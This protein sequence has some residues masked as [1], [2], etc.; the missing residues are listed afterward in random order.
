MFAVTIGTY[1]AFDDVVTEIF[2]GGDEDL[3]GLQR[4]VRE[5]VVIERTRNLDADP[6]Y[7]IAQLTTVAWSS[8]S[9]SK[10]NPTPGLETIF[11]LRDLLARWSEPQGRPEGEPVPVVYN[12]DLI[13]EAITSLE[14]L[15]VVASESMQ[16]QCYA[17]VVRTFSKLFDRLAVRDQERVDDAVLRIL[18]GLGDLVLSADLDQA[19]RDLAGT[20]GSNGHG[21]AA[22][23][24]RTARDALAASVG[25]LNS[26]S[27]RV[28][29]S[30][31][32]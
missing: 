7:G 13:G 22:S 15:A 29:A 18:S 6:A 21:A 25:S 30:G 1:V 17:E 19:L 2:R 24:V 10:Q 3:E 14:S 16:H 9:T 28:P 31:E 11:A 26:R 5:A 27:T 4:V 23:A 8:I 32:S 20:L 12:D